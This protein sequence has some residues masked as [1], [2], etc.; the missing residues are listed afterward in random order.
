MRALTEQKGPRLLEILLHR[1]PLH[2]DDF[3]QREMEIRGTVATEMTWWK[4]GRGRHRRF[5][6]M[7]YGWVVE[8]KE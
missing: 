3:R 4:D 5:P 7:A 2:T 6:F 8:G 1:L